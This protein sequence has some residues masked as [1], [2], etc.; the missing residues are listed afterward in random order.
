M[1]NRLGRAPKSEVGRILDYAAAS[2]IGLLDTAAAYGISEAVLGETLSP[3]HP[4]RIVTKTRPCH[5]A[6]VTAPEQKRVVETFHRSLRKLK[7]PR[8]Y[9]LLVHNADDLLLPGGELLVDALHQ[10]KA[11]GLVEKIGVSVYIG[12]QIDAVAR[13]FTP[14][15]VQLPVNLLD[16]R[17]IH[18][19]HLTRL[20]QAG[21]EI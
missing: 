6:A 21:V 4:F 14:D 9:G 8:V 2:G 20:K 18:G 13:I 19:G 16:Q 3:G 17:L 1:S 5:C 11:A 15:L 12:D 7:Q 10:L